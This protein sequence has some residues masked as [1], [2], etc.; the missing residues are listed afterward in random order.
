MKKNPNQVPIL[1]TLKLQSPALAV[2][3]KILNTSQLF[4]KSKLVSFLHYLAHFLCTYLFVCI[5]HKTTWRS[6]FSFHY[7]GPRD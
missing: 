4:F 3:G 1:L 2:S 7:V 6:W 5:G